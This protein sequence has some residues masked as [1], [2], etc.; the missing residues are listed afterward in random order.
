MSAA[1]SDAYFATRNWQSRLGA[2]ASQQSEPIAS[3]AELLRQGGEGRRCAWRCRCPPTSSSRIPDCTLR[4]RR[5]GAATGCGPR[6]WNCGSRAARASTIARAGSAT[7]SA[8]GRWLRTRVRGPPRDCSPERLRPSEQ[9][10]CGATYALAILVGILFFVAVGSWLDQHRTTSWEHTV[11]VGA[12]PVNADGSAVAAA[13]I[14]RARRGAAATGQ[15]FRRARGASLR[16]GD[17]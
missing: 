1:E 5:T 14:A 10:R 8:A 13:Y 9:A 6:R 3:R 16:R 2:W 12:F 11:R 4:A 17:R 15:R 7:L